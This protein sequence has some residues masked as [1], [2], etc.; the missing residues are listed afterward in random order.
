MAPIMMAARQTDW[1]TV[2]NGIVV[3]I[4]LALVAAIGTYAANDRNH[5]A[6]IQ[7]RNVERIAVLEQQNATLRDESQRVRNRVDALEQQVIA[8]H[9]ALFENG[10]RKEP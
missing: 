10:Y 4:L 8:L 2:V 3:A 6:E 7:Q 9:R 5:I 1:K